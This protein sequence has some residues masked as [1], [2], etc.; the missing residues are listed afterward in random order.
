M[1]DKILTPIDVAKVFGVS[2]KTVGRWARDEK[3][4]SFRTVG[5]HLRFYQSDVAIALREA[6]GHNE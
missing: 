4:K 3:I 2:P 6:G 5:G 1:S